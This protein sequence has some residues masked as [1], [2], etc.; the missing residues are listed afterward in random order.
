MSNKVTI[1]SWITLGHASIAE[2][3][4]DAGFDWLCIDIEHTVIDLL[5]VQNLIIAIQSKGKKAYVRV[6]DNDNVIIKKVLDAGANGII[7]PLIK[8][9]NDAKKAIANSFYPP[10]GSRGVNS[11][12]RAQRYG[13]GFKDYLLS[14]N[15][16]TE[17]FLQIEHINAID[18]LEEI[19]NVKGISGTIIGPYDLSASIGKPGKFDDKEVINAI[20]RYEAICKK[21]NKTMG[22]HVT[23][24][25]FKKINNK[26]KKGYNFIG[27]SWD[28]FF[29]GQMCKDQLHKIR[30]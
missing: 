7:V 8:N 28:T 9:S 5:E 26:I 21:K 19:L 4:A 27:F 1:G 12:S 14:V 6:G 29:L 20:K 25:D 15:K 10:L 23:E 2:L 17:V 22:Y 13:F 30:K 16:K 18:D 24:P 11:A 3:M